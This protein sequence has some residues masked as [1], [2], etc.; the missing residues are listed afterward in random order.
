[1]VKIKVQ[2]TTDWESRL[3][4]RQKYHQVTHSLP[5]Y[6]FYDTIVNTVAMNQVVVISGETGSGKSTQI[7]QYLLQDAISKQ[8]SFS[9]ICT[10]VY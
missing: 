2:S 4:E 3:P 8:S 1:M 9:L 7:P 10:Q 5:V 6:S